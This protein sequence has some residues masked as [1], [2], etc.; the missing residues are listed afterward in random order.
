[1]KINQI[2]KTEYFE[3]HLIKHAEY[4]RQEQERITF[5][6]DGEIQAT[7]G[8]MSKICRR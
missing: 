3:G 8:T 4:V 6:D 5:Q 7:Y 2:E 1:M